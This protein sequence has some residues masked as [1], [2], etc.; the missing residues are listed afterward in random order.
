MRNGAWPKEKKSGIKPLLVLVLFLASALSLSYSYHCRPSDESFYYSNNPIFKLSYNS[1]FEPDFSNVLVQF[2]DRSGHSVTVPYEIL[3]KRDYVWAVLA[4][5][6]TPGKDQH[7]VASASPGSGYQEQESGDFSGSTGGNRPE[8]KNFPDRGD[9]NNTSTNAGNGGNATF[10]RP[11]DGRVRISEAVSDAEGNRLETEIM[12][13]SESDSSAVYWN[14]GY[15]HSHEIP[16]GAYT[17]KIR[18]KNHPIESITI[19]NFNIDAD[20]NQIIDL[21]EPDESVVEGPPGVRFTELYAVNPKADVSGTFTARAKGSRVYK[22]ADWDFESRACLGEWKNIL[23]VTPGEYYTI[24]FNS[25]DPAYGEG[26]DYFTLRSITVDGEFE[27]WEAVLSNPNN[28]IEDGIQG[29]NDNDAGQTADRDL[30]L[31]AFTWDEDYLYSYFRRTS[32][33]NRVVQ[34]LLYI[35]TD[36]DGLLES[37]DR[38]VRYRWPNN[39]QWDSYLYNYSPS[40]A[41]GDPI[42]GDGVNEPGGVAGETSLESSIQGGCANNIKVET[43]INWSSLNLTPGSPVQFHVSSALG[44]GTNLPGQIEDNLNSL[45]TLLVDVEI[46]PD[47]EGAGYNGDTVYYNHTVTNLGNANDTFDIKTTGT[48]PGFA[49][50]L[51]YA[52][53]TPLADSDNDTRPD[54]GILGPGES[55]NITLAIT[56]SGASSGDIDETFVTATSSTNA[57]VSDSAKDATSIG[58]VVIYPSRSGRIINGSTVVYNHTVVS[59]LPGNNT[60]NLNAASNNSYVVNLTYVN[61]TYLSD[62]NS[63]G[64]V[65]IGNVSQG[66]SVPIQARISV[67]AAALIGSQDI[68]TVAALQ[69]SDNTVNS[70]VN[71]TTTVSPPIDIYPNRTGV[72]AVTGYIFYRHTVVNSLNVSDTAD[73]TNSSSRNWS[74]TYF[75]L[76]KVTPLNDTDGDSIPDTGP[77]SPFGG[78]RDIYVRVHVYPPLVPD[79]TEDITNI[80]VNSSIFPSESDF[81][82]DNTTARLL[83]TFEDAAHT[84]FEDLFNNTQTVY[85]NSYGLS[86]YKKVYYMWYDSNGTLVRQSPAL[87]VDSND[88]AADQLQLNASLPVGQYSVYIHND[89]NGNVISTEYFE[90]FGVANVTVVS[91]NGGEYWSGNRT[92]YYN[93]TDNSGQNL[94]VT[95]QYSQNN[96]SSW[97]NIT[98][99]ILNTTNCSFDPSLQ[100]VEGQF[101]YTWDTT[102]VSDGTQYLVRIVANNTYFTGSDDSDGVFTIDNS[103]C[104]IIDSPGSYSL[105]SNA[106]GAPFNASEVAGIGWACIKIAS[107]DVGF[108]CIGYNITNDGTSDAAGIVVNGS[109]SVN[110]TNVTIRNCPGVSGYQEGIYVHQTSDNTVDNSSSFSNTADGLL[111]FNST[112]ISFLNNNAYNNS[113][114]GICL[115]Q[116]SGGN[117]TGNNIT[118]NGAGGAVIDSFSSFNSLDSNYICFNGFDLSGKG[119]N[120]SGQMD[121][122]DSFSG[123][124]ENGHLGCTYTCSDFWH[125]F[126][127]NING[128][129]VLTHSAAIQYVYSWTFSEAQLY[130]TDADESINWGQLQAIGRNTTNGTSSDDF[131]ELDNALNGTGFPDN[132][133]STYSSDGSAPLETGNYAVF[134]KQISH[135]PLANSSVFNTS[136]KTGILWD[137]GDGGSEY[138][139]ALNQSTVWVVKA[140]QSTPDTF[141]T[142]GFLVQVPYT[143]STSEPNNDAIAIYAG[144]Q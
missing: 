6:R 34:L 109:V 64:L 119:S 29:V 9:A 71:D 84:R 61:G 14:R 111:V 54:T 65:D 17:I 50:N 104:R 35:D 63:D 133:N 134:S 18:P 95:I 53:G 89:K 52:N 99:V 87:D 93:I 59:N 86:A 90:V 101:N 36:N 143:L 98:T 130:F 37:S 97:S 10:F 55:V 15:C 94:S 28:V 8:R 144:F 1:E 131:I 112:N 81:V 66:T 123:W 113:A 139:N 70:S 142:Y 31:Y 38:V 121:R 105:G 114:Y 129:I 40:N 30:T 58:A 56:I 92:I 124:S 51:T 32:S 42:T 45:N 2:V 39:G 96:G 16:A 44:S 125:R 85:A 106:L 33:G 138:S 3:S 74:V 107:S 110:Y 83:I 128:S 24:E 12:F 4:L 46:F 135:V 41:S 77:I 49:V 137:A 126:F 60:I 76:D 141:G 7:I 11:W 43:R 67:P 72:V 132:I 48:I 140:N 88:E 69:A 5:G 26:S 122:C 21:D 13:I 100:C 73:I 75:D 118:G 80:T 20:V 120:N 115:N 62:S 102:T 25:T 22:C 108:D 57:G 91:P 82:S 79:D 103:G 127:G 47:N 19:R 117:L 78:T 23:N 68:T 27:D 116:S 136:F